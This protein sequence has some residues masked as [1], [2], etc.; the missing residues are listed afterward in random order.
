MLVPD[1]TLPQSSQLDRLV[2]L[3]S[4]Y[5]PTPHCL[6]TTSG[7]L[8]LQFWPWLLGHLVSIIVQYS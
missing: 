5:I 4:Q 1:K 2:F 6:P 3:S 7:P 8:G